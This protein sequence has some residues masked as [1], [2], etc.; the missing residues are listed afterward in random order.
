M[1]RR[2]FHADFVVYDKIIIKAKATSMLVATFT[3]QTLNHLKASGLDFGIVVNFGQTSLQYKRI[4]FQL[5]W[6]YNINDLTSNLS[7]HRAGSDPPI[8]KNGLY[9]LQP[10]TIRRRFGAVLFF[11][12]IRTT[13]CYNP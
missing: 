12:D 1:L 7:P 9:L 11:I 6:F 10:K 4:V 13:V 2:Q 5:R 3:R 8:S